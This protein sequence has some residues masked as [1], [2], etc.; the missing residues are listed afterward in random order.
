MKKI[1]ILALL[2]NQ[3]IS[4]SQ[5]PSRNFINYGIGIGFLG[6]DEFNLTSGLEYN[7]G[8]SRTMK[9][10]RIK[11]NP[12]IGFGS[13][14]G[15]F[16]DNNREQSINSLNIRLLLN[17]ELIRIKSFS[18]GI[19]VGGVLGYTHGLKG[20]GYSYDSAKS[21]LIAETESEYV[22]RI[23]IGGIIGGG[24]K[25]KPIGKNY[26]LNLM[27]INISAGNG[28]GHFYSDISVG[29]NLK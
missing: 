20:T 3:A 14:R 21:I 7:V 26:Y 1:L 28:F 25:Y 12:N 6:A 9:N 13:Y 22:S 5:E 4:Y 11:I 23:N 8:Y 19:D 29:I 10:D 27:P 18:I 17:Y 16:I 24:L 15:E 2:L